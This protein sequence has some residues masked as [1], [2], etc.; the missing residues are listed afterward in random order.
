[1]RHLVWAFSPTQWVGSQIPH[2]SLT[3][4]AGFPAGVE[5]EPEAFS[6]ALPLRLADSHTFCCGQYHR[7]EGPGR[8]PAYP[9]DDRHPLSHLARD[10]KLRQHLNAST[11]IRRS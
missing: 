10:R 4:V 8:P 9:A 2:P 7:C 6:P 1:M 5:G 11:T 3:E